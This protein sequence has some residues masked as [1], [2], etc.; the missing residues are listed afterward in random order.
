MNLSGESVKEVLDFYKAGPEDLI[1][2]YDDISLDIG[3]LRAR[4]KGS[5]GGHN[6]IKSIISHLG[7]EEFLRIKIGVGEKPAQYDLA[8]YVLG[9]FTPSE[10]KVFEEGLKKSAD[11]VETI[12]TQGIDACM[13]S[14][15]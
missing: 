8:D 3:R 2:L 7:T 9:R 14:I 1:V 15:N 5:A 4:R 11:G 6:G 12:L 13:N 10:R